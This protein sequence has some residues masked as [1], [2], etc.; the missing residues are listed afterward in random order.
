MADYW[1]KLYLAILDDPK[2]AVLP[3][4]LWRRVIELFLMAGK[5]GKDGLLPETNQIAWMLRMSTDDLSLDMQQIASTGII[6]R[7]VNGWIVA[8]FAKRQAASTVNERIKAFRE[9]QHREQYNSEPVTELKR[10]VTQI[11]RLTENRLTE[12]D[13]ETENPP[14]PEVFGVYEREIGALTGMIAQELISAETEYPPGWIEQAIHEAA[15][16]NKRSW[17]YAQAILK[18]WK[19]EGFQS[20]NKTKQGV[21]GIHFDNVRHGD[22]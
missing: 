4:R 16:N 5:M 21:E 1:I 7:T 19:V 10:E 11:N 12:P 22:G 20:N 17:K 13:A 2:M 6:E 3:D 14:R 9:K 18:R 15:T 8:K